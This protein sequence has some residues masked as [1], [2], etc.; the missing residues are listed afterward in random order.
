[1]NDEVMNNDI[2]LI[3]ISAILRNCKFWRIIED[4][5]LLPSK[6]KYIIVT[7]SSNAAMVVLKIQTYQR[8]FMHF[9]Q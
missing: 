4:R 1:V 7:L 9:A 6:N 2:Y 5:T 3:Y 8:D